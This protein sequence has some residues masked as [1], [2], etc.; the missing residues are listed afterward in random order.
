MEPSR[1]SIPNLS[2]QPPAV[3]FIENHLDEYHPAFGTPTSRYDPELDR[4]II[5]DQLPP[6]ST[7]SMSSTQAAADATGTYTFSPRPLA[8]PTAALKFWDSMFDRSKE[9]FKAAHPKEPKEIVD[10][11]RSIRSQSDWT[12]VFD[13]LEAAK[14]G[15]CNVDKGFQAGFR[16]VYRKFSEHVANPVLGATKF[17]PN[18]DYVTPVLGAVQILLEAIKTA[19]K[20]RTEI[21]DSVDEI[22]IKFSQVEMFLELFKGDKNIEKASVKLIASVFHG[23]ECAIA[24]EELKNLVFLH[25]MFFCGLHED[26]FTDDYIGG[27]AMIESFICQLLCQYDFSA[28]APAYMVSEEL[29]YEDDRGSGFVSR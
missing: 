25:L 2:L 7:A 8:E 16:E 13:Q 26:P 6:P 20:V 19:S 24:L 18:V 12:A 14:Q 15:Y 5:C 4:F 1:P 17:V 22:D 3:D 10:K 23:I 11:G 21:L 27:R 29:S 28:T 9:Q